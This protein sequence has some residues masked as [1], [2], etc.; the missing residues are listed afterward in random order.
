MSD[1]F[2][3][4]AGLMA[5]WYGVWGGLSRVC[6]LI[7]WG[8]LGLLYQP[9]LAHGL[10][11]AGTQIDSRASG[12]YF[13]MGSLRQRTLYS[14]AV[15]LTVQAVPALALSPGQRQS[16]GVDGGAVF[17]H[18]VTNTGNVVSGYQLD[19]AATTCPDNGAAIFPESVYWDVNNDG[20]IGA[21][22]VLLPTGIAD[23]VWALPGQSLRLALRF[24]PP[25]IA[26]ASTGTSNRNVSLD[27]CSRFDVST[28]FPGVSAFAV[29]QISMQPLAEVQLTLAVDPAAASSVTNPVWH[30]QLQA[31]NVGIQAA[32]PTASGAVGERLVVDGTPQSS[33]LLHMDML[34]AWGLQP[35]TLKTTDPSAQVLYRYEDDAAAIYWSHE[36]NGVELAEVALALPTPLPSGAAIGLSFDAY[37]SSQNRDMV[38]QSAVIYDA[39]NGVIERRLSKVLHSAD[40]L[41]LWLAASAPIANATPDGSPDGTADVKFRL[42]LRN[43][44]SRLLFDV[45]LP[46]PLS[47]VRGLGTY[48]PALL[49]AAG[50][51][52]VLAQSLQLVEIVGSGTFASINPL[53]N[54]LAGNSN[55]LRPGSLLGEEGALTVEVVV[56]FHLD[57]VPAQLQA[58]AQA[59]A[60]HRPGGPIEARALSHNGF[61]L[62]SGLSV[63]TAANFDGAQLATPFS[64]RPPQLKLNMHLESTQAVQG[65][66]G[67]FDLTYALRI[68]NIGRTD[69][70]Y[71]RLISDLQCAF[72][73]GASGGPVKAW[74]IMGM[75]SSDSADLPVMPGFTGAS[76]CDANGNTALHAET[77]LP[78]APELALVDG[79]FAL[80]VG[81]TEGLRVTARLTLQP[82][83]SNLPQ[84]KPQAWVAVVQ[85]LADVPPSQIVNAND[86]AH[87]ILWSSS[88]QVIGQVAMP[89]GTV[90]HALTRQPVVAAVVTVQRSGCTQLADS[91]LVDGDLVSTGNIRYHAD[92]TASTLTDSQGRYFLS[93]NVAANAGVCT[94]TLRVAGPLGSGLAFPSQKIEPQAG[95]FAS[96]GA[97]SARNSAPQAGDDSTYFTQISQGSDAQSGAACTVYH[98]HIPLDMQAQQGLSLQKR[99]ESNQVEWG[100]LVGYELRL[101]NYTGS[102]LDA[103]QLTDALPVGLR[104]AAGSATIN[105]N[106]LAEPARGTPNTME[107]ALPPMSPGASSTLRYFVRAGVGAE[108]GTSLVNRAWA[109]AI[110]GQGVIK[111]NTATAS[112]RVDGGVFSEFAYAF[113]K[114]FGDCNANGLQDELERG[115]PSVRL[116]LEDGTSVF[117]D[118]DGKWSLPGLRPLS[119][120][121]RLD[122]STLPPGTSPRLLQTRQLGVANSQWLDLKKGEWRKVNFAV[123][124]C[125]TQAVALPEAAQRSASDVSSKTEQSLEEAVAG[126][127]AEP[128]F[129][130]SNGPSV[131]PGSVTHVRVMGPLRHKLTLLLNGVEV[132]RSRIGQQLDDPSRDLLARDY[133]ALHLRAGD[134][135]FELQTTDESGV[136]TTRAQQHVIAP[137]AV[138]KIEL[139]YPES[140]AANVKGDVVLNLRLT[141]ADGVAVVDQTPVT[142]ELQGAKWRL[143]D[144]SPQTSSVPVMVDGGALA[145]RLEPPAQPGEAHFKVTAGGVTQTGRIIF[146]PDLRPLVGVGVLD[147]IFHLNR[148]A[149][150]LVG[151]APAGAAFESELRA[152]SQDDGHAVGRSAFYFKGAVKGAYL[153]TLAFDSEK[154]ARSPLFKEIEPDRFYPVYGDE[155]TRQADAQ[156]S[157]RLYL[158]VDHNRSYLLVGDYQVDSGTGIDAVRR[159]SRTNRRKS[160]IAQV[161]Q[162]DSTRVSSHISQGTTR[163]HTQEFVANGTSGPFMLHAPGDLVEQSEFVEIVVRDRYQPNVI[164]RT[165]SL[166]RFI[167]YNLDMFSQS[168]LLTAPVASLDADLNLQSIRVRY[169]VESGGAAYWVGGVAAEQQI[170][171]SV[172]LGGV[173]EQDESPANATEMR[174][175]TLT[176]Q[177][178]TQTQLSSEWVTTDSD[179][180]GAGQA[181]GLQL[182]HQ[183]DGLNYRLQSHS[184]D[185]NFHNPE[186]GVIAGATDSQAQ[187]ELDLRPDVQ[188]RAKVHHTENGLSNTYRK[189]PSSVGHGGA[190]SGA[191]VLLHHTLSPQF[192]ADWGVQIGSTPAATTGN[193][194]YRTV[195]GAGVPTRFTAQDNGTYE[196]ANDQRTGLWRLT[197]NPKQS[198]GVGLFVEGEQSLDDADR[199]MT[200]L[201][202]NFAGPQSLRL[203]GR[204]ESRTGL[205]WQNGSEERQL[206]RRDVAIMGIDSPYRSSGRIYQELRVRERD[207]SSGWQSAM[208]VRDSWPLTDS[209]RLT[210]SVERQ[211]GWSS[212]DNHNDNASVGEA[213]AV[214]SGLHWTGRGPLLNRWRGSVSTEWR[215]AIGRQ[216]RLTAISA[217]Y[218]INSG[219]S[220]LGKAQISSVAHDA[221][222]THRWQ[223][224]QQIGLA[225]RPELD[226]TWN[227]LFRYERRHDHTSTPQARLNKQ[228]LTHIGSA[229]FNF[230]PRLADQISTRLA[231]RHSEEQHGHWR[232]HY[233][234]ALWHSR[235]THEWR[236]GWDAGLQGGLWLDQHGTQQ[237]TAGVE[238]GH[239]LAPGFW[240]S[241]GYNFIGLRDGELAG[242]DYI[243]TGWYL[244]MRFK[245]DER[246]L[247]KQ[248]PAEAR[249]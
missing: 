31:K 84:F 144:L 131:L 57:A 109:T 244:R 128:Q 180:Q 1:H 25:D 41:N 67:S 29:N 171:D 142:L 151:Q 51:Y 91:P 139:S 110:I 107:F 115:L 23:S 123:G 66:P 201:G 3:R 198:Q 122:E 236:T 148:H 211:T 36:R 127:S 106:A 173:I 11:E 101:T 78:H 62:A 240:L 5:P 192:Q 92:G 249:P 238:V 230:Q 79:P 30:F 50:Q 74:Q 239:T 189:R 168:L 223:G 204:Y 217:A 147:G 231:A 10:P 93:P 118:S 138:A 246:S 16:V 35:G 242:V 4:A 94:Y 100:D 48:T 15:S 248:R 237:R 170:T 212:D 39:G 191:Q 233:A 17:F 141:D 195:S 227:A 132:D 54:G 190:A 188:L 56:R 209:L 60:S 43:P 137:G 88:A 87:A 124:P 103:V 102:A 157:Q 105:G 183:S 205:E 154:P 55:L 143:P 82:S 12:L 159:L 49:P 69:V 71:V 150:L 203:Y 76:P 120:A 199:R 210:G 206:T 64:G 46:F 44:Q 215:E 175:V 108:I 26:Q 136:T 219:W 70:E 83:V 164:V 232:D 135:L 207:D 68:D 214:T 72:Q 202:A 200:A 14:N 77:G 186:A 34:H 53:F 52:T 80:P 2:G 111:S 174:A 129:L 28:G 21:D 85:P 81:S 213:V 61:P 8:I 152:W 235:W 247:S 24:K 13:E 243:D 208:G 178:D 42:H 86:G 114:V 133:V 216:T 134:N 140:A 156:S 63:G 166:A 58:R 89:T 145:L 33:V 226:D 38:A 146:L 185:K 40:P 32:S 59:S 99:A 228:R 161:F 229:H 149:P 73:M 218:K 96:C 37:A 18:T 20:Q 95:V 90:Y 158:R 172:K 182:A 193:F 116:F 19:F 126:R 225:Y 6:G 121:V 155:S 75:P 65:E 234:A 196:T 241:V 112:V 47:G 98:N 177:V 222:L 162:G 45:A 197:M 125:V 245:F 119:H 113:G 187:L 224:R 221:G 181:R 194:D 27:Y 184:S 7:V 104:Y 153:L 165:T 167:H 179:E 22:D 220:L 97:V 160:G 176:H 117:T 169:D 9:A 130:S 163:Q